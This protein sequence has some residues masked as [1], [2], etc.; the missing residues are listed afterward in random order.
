M[1]QNVIPVHMSVCPK[2]FAVNSP[3]VRYCFV[4]RRHGRPIPAAEVMRNQALI[5]ELTTLLGGVAPIF[6]DTAAFDFTGFGLSLKDVETGEEFDCPVD[7]IVV[8]PG[9]VGLPR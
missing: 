7:R 1:R 6:A 8:I 9:K 5:C 3:D 2:C 4:S